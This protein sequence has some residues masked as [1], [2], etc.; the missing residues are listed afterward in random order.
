[1]KAVA[2]EVALGIQRLDVQEQLRRAKDAA[3]A[4]N[5]AKSEFLANMSHEI[6]TPMN[7]VLGMAELALSTELTAEQHEYLSA[8]Q[9][10]GQALLAVING[11]LDFSK[12]EAGKLEF[13]LIDFSLRETVGEAIKSLALKAHEK[14]L[15]LTY[16]V[17]RVVPE[18]LI[19]DPH[20]LRQV[21]VNLIGNAIKFTERGEVAACMRV[22]SATEQQVHLHFCVRDTGIGIRADQRDLI[23][24]PFIQADGSITR[25]F[26]GTGLGLTISTQLVER[27]GGRIWVESEVG[28][29]SEFHFTAWFER[30]KPRDNVP[31]PLPV[32]ALEGLRILVVDDNATN[33]RILLGTLKE[34]RMNAQAAGTAAEAMHALQSAR[35]IGQPFQVLL[36]DVVMPD[37]DGFTLARQIRA[38]PDFSG[39][40]LVFL[41]SAHHQGG[42]GHCRE[43]GRAVF[44]IKPVKSS[45]LLQG[46]AK[47]LRFSQVKPMMRPDISFVRQDS[48]AAGMRI[49]LAEDNLINQTVA[50]HMLTKLGHQVTVVR[51]GRE[52]VH[53]TQAQSFDLVLMDVQMPEVDGYEATRQIRARERQTQSHVPIFALTAYAIKGDHEQ[54]LAAGMDGYVAKPIAVK[55][56]AQVIETVR[57]AGPPTRSGSEGHAPREGRPSFPLRVGGPANDDEILDRDGLLNRI[58][59]NRALLRQLVGLLATELPR[60][61]TSLRQALQAGDARASEQAAHALKGAI[62]NLGA[63]KAFS[64]VRDMEQLAQQRQLTQAT[65]LLA[66]LE[67][68][69]P[70]FQ[71]ALDQL[72]NED[73]A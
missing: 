66:V 17:D 72:A 67:R 34:W 1:M 10:S 38:H 60:L 73:T 20:R 47:V 48:G 63:K 3:E 31:P 61:L 18:H 39:M 32:P 49:L 42:L 58:G 28:Q 13:D 64:V 25:K 35:Q 56:L 12:I 43:F 7:G 15:E 46:I 11:I 8:I 44:L 29:G 22:E 9:S 45:D 5:R 33:R 23:F 69:L 52:A 26:G 16:E 19:G 62:V 41:S 14:Q 50:V 24:Q 65:L 4:A 40:P 21:L 6:R 53:M 59:H 57:F 37:V 70:S 2:D 30:G 68:E 55:D 54:C 51:N 71:A 36:L 27:M